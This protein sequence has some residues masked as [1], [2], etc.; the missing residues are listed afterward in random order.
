VLCARIG[1]TPWD[2]LEQAGI[3]PVADYAMEP[4]EASI[5][6]LYAQWLSEGRLANDSTECAIA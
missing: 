2:A 1:M 6:A 3:T 5:A 4:I